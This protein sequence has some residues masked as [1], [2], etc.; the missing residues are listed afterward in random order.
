MLQALRS[1]TA[2]TLTGLACVGCGGKAAAGPSDASGL[3]AFT[4]DDARLFDDDI[5]AEIF[6]ATLGGTRTSPPELIR[7]RA[8]R[9]DVVVPAKIS[10]V[11]RDTNS[12]GGQALYHLSL[13]PTGAALVGTAGDTITLDVGAQSPAFPLI[14]NAEAAAVG[15]SVIAFYRRFNVGDQVALHFRC[16]PD[17]P[18]VRR[19]VS[20]Q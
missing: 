14:R 1:A 20:E 4:P 8:K 17:L 19:A 5:A 16:E 11:T 2:L 9:A 15:K 3:P 13:R 18:A 6:G 12:Q 10:T 7:E